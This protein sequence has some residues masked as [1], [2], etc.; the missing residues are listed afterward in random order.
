M[1]LVQI[2]H[3]ANRQPSGCS[4]NDWRRKES[5]IQLAARGDFLW[6][7]RFS[8]WSGSMKMSQ[9]LTWLLSWLSDSCRR[10]ILLLYFPQQRRTS[11]HRPHRES[12]RQ[13]HDQGWRFSGLLGSRLS[14][15][16]KQWN[17]LPDLLR[18]R[19]DNL[20]LWSLYR[21]QSCTEGWSGRR[22]AMEG[23]WLHSKTS[24]C[25]S[26]L[27]KARQYLNSSRRQW[28]SMKMPSVGW[29][30]WET[31]QKLQTSRNVC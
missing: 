8:S 20:P 4:K 15:W 22:R 7:Y 2:P 29:G 13:G 19:A 5:R 18:D 31:Q 24:K 28:G 11:C 26:R 3:R 12:R 10:R 17:H 30:E 21:N 6:K 14:M 23:F 25:L 27:W 9:P 1:Y 16:K